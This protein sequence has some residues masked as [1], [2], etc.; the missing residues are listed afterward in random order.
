M[1][2]EIEKRG[3]S[4]VCKHENVNSRNAMMETLAIKNASLWVTLGEV[5][6]HRNELNLL[7]G[8]LEHTTISKHAS[9]F[10]GKAPSTYGRQEVYLTKEY[11]MIS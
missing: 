4:A 1:E 10:R 5:Y 8:V 6:L 11:L 3:C 2:V 9:K 7:V